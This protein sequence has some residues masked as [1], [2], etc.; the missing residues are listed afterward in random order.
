MGNLRNQPNLRRPKNRFVQLI[1]KGSAIANGVGKVGRFVGNAISGISSIARIF[2]SGAYTIQSNTLLSGPPTFSAL[3]SGVR[4]HHREYLGDITSSTGFTNTTYRI[5]PND[6]V[7]F[8]WLSQMA[9]SFEQYKI[10]G[11]LVYL[12]TTCGSA[13]SST[14][15]ALGVWGVTTVYDPSRPALPNKLA[16]EEYS[17]C[18]SSVPSVSVLHPI[19]CK[20]K[21]DVLERYYI[22]YSNTITGE[23]LKFY[24]HGKINVFTQGMQLAGITL[25][26][27]WISYDISFFNPRIQPAGED[28]VSDHYKLSGNTISATNPCGTGALL[29]PTAGS[30]L[31]SQIQTGLSTG[32]GTL[33]LPNGS[34]AGIYLVSY[35]YNN[36]TN[37]V[38]SPTLGIYVNT[39]NMVLYNMFGNSPLYAFN[40]PGPALSNQYTVIVSFR[41]TDTNSAILNIGSAANVLPSAATATSVDIFVT[42]L[43]SAIAGGLTEEEMFY[44]KFKEFTKR[45]VDE[46]NKEDSFDNMI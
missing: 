23:N 36:P 46:Q 19:E 11:M 34:A 14:N 13:I 39:S 9:N 12:N 8:P 22:D 24:D 28:N 27:L 45:F 7:T 15:N 1:N 31:G 29:S 41:K 40:P 18:T 32:V 42:P 25:G 21:T 33:T 37:T 20:P 10:H 5:Q 16:A 30:L 4:I 17:G 38:A 6:P 35:L 43:G 3:E 44:A 26:E 2:G